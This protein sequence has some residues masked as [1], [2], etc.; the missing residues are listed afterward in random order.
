M[1]SMLLCLNHLTCLFPGFH[2]VSLFCYYE[3]NPGYMNS[4]N[5]DIEH[6]VYIW[7]FSYL[8]YPLNVSISWIQSL[9]LYNWFYPYLYLSHAWCLFACLCIPML[10]TLFS[11]HVF[12]PTLS[13]HIYLLDFGLTT[14]SLFSIYVLVIAC[15]CMPESHHLIMYT[16]DYLSTLPGF[17]L[18]TCWVVFWQPWTFMSR[19]KSQDRGGLIL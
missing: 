3:G 4:G 1:T 13:I 17:I 5:G 16:C 15:T 8:D 14:N 12:Y 9:S 10:S 18:S 19:S 7:G 2:S 11:M 6:M